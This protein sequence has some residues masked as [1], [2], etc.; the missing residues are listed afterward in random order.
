MFLHLKHSFAVIVCMSLQLYGVA[1]LNVV[2]T[3]CCSESCR[4]VICN[5]QT[6]VSPC[7]SSSLDILSRTVPAWVFT[8]LLWSVYSRCGE[9][10]LRKAVRS[11]TLPLSSVPLVK[12]H[13]INRPLAI[14]RLAK[15]WSTC[16]WLHW[17]CLCT[18]HRYTSTAV[19]MLSGLLAF[20]HQLN[21]LCFT[22]PQGHT[23]EEEKPNSKSVQSGRERNG[24]W[25]GRKTKNT[26]KSKQSHGW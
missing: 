15:L 18:G 4:T 13:P 3:W 24:H 20:P 19:L 7:S 26:N 25:E 1:V 11:W 14:F 9:V 17:W 5:K 12:Q 6:S 21:T 22:K 23:R 8:W 16:Q 2:S 10:R